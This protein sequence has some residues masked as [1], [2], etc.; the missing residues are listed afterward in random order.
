VCSLRAWRP[1]ALSRALGSI[2]APLDAVPNPAHSG[3]VRIPS[4]PV[5]SLIVVLGKVNGNAATFV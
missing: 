1:L 2:V 5:Q 3:T 4:A